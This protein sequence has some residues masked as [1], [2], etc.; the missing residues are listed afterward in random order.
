[1]NCIKRRTIVWTFLVAAVSFMCL[2]RSSHVHAQDKQD[3]AQETPKPRKVGTIKSLNGSTITLQPDSGPDLMVILQDSTRLLRIAPG[4]RDLSNAA[5]IQAQDLQTGDRMLVRGKVRDQD[6]AFLADTLVVIRK[7]DIADKRQHERQDWQ[8]RGVGGIVSSVNQVGGTVTI[9]TAPGHSVTIKTSKDTNFL[10]YASGSVRFADAKSSAFDEIKAG[11]Q[12]RAR[13]TRSEDGKELAAEQVI[14]GTFRN[15][16]GLVL[17]VDPNANTIT[18]SDLLTKKPVVVNVSANCQLHKLTPE[19]GQM[20]VVL[21]SQSVAA[22][23]SGSTGQANQQA[24]GSN[25]AAPRPAATPDFARM[26]NLVPPAKIGDLQKGD[27]VMIVS[28]NGVNKASTSVN[29]ITLLAGAEP[30][31]RA[32]ESSNGAMILSRWNIAAVPVEQ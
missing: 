28:D 5:P 30:I 3:A 6:Q 8:Q 17:G 16:A 27:A 21:L 25:S 24:Q 4:E 20:A 14:S 9:S 11:D 15:I 2:G 22:S 31:L 23:P 10:R 12:L 19:M 26:L 32:V 7:T 29:A 13:G 1:M 18:V